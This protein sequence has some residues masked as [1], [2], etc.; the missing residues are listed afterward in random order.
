ML[1]DGTGRV[2]LTLFDSTYKFV[3][4]RAGLNLGADV[5]VTAEVTE[6]QGRA[7]IAAEFR[8]RC[9]DHHAGIVGGVPVTTINQLGKPGELVAIE[10][11]I[12]DVKGFSA[13]ANVFVDDGT[14]NVRVTL[15][16]NVL[17]YVPRDR[18]VPGAAVRVYG[19]T[20]RVRRRAAD[21]AGAG[22]RCDLQMTTDLLSYLLIAVLGALI[23]SLL[24]LI[25]ALHVYNVITLAFLFAGGLQA[26]LQ[27][28]QFAMLLLGM[29][30]GYAVLQRHPFHL[31]R[32][33]R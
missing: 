21:C 31:S 16:N 1:D 4:N 6:F 28:D 11:T 24:A 32:R 23:A 7:G 5:Q 19:K 18:L 3:P 27:P 25:P 2:Q 9:A 12:T 8:P 33:A 26:W 13:G 29:V 30:T 17:A 22:L 10:G 15:F 20:R 14:G